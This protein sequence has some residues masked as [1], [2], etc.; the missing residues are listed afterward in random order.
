MI[1]L[2]NFSTKIHKSLYPNLFEVLSMVRK[3]IAIR[4]H[5]HPNSSDFGDIVDDM[6]V[7]I[8]NHYSD[9]LLVCEERLSFIKENYGAGVVMPLTVFV[10]Y[11]NKKTELYSVTI[12]Y[13]VR[14]IPLIEYRRL[15]IHSERVSEIK[16]HLNVIKLLEFLSSN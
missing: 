4:F 1:T 5:G 2:G 12:N 8:D 15:N 9:D 14:S 6:N 16:T 11:N 3:T 7:S 13:N 10:E